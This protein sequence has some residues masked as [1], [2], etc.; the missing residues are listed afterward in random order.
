MLFSKMS[1]LPLSLFIN[2][3]SNVLLFCMCLI[4]QIRSLES[5]MQLLL[6]VQETKEKAATEVFEVQVKDLK[7]RRESMKKREKEMNDLRAE[8]T[9]EMA[10]I[11]AHYVE[12]GAQNDEDDNQRDENVAKTER[13]KDFRADS[14]NSVVSVNE[15]YDSIVWPVAT[16]SI[17]LSSTTGSSLYSYENLYGDEEEEDEVVTSP[18][19]NDQDLSVFESAA[20]V[21]W[22]GGVR[23]DASAQSGLTFDS[24]GGH[25]DEA[26][27]TIGNIHVKQLQKKLKL[28]ESSLLK[29]HED[30]E[31][32]ER[33]KYRLEYQGIKR[34][35]QMKLD[36]L[37]SQCLEER[38]RL[39]DDVTNRMNTLAQNQELST[40]TVQESIDQDMKAMQDALVEYWRLELA[41]KS[42]F[43]KAQA[44]IS[45]QVFHEVRNALSSV[46]AMSEMTS[47]LKEDSSMLPS[48]LF[49]YVNDMLLQNG[50]VVNYA[51]NMLNNVMDISKMKSGEF[52][53]KK[54]AFDLQHLVQQATTMQLVKAEARGVK[55]NCIPPP[56]RCIA[57]TDSDIVSRIITNFISNAVKFTDSG[58]IQPFVLPA[59]ELLPSLKVSMQISNGKQLRMMAVGVADT[60]CGLSR[61][62]LNL[63]EAGLFNSTRGTSNGAKNRYV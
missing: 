37:L 43:D 46:V 30:E 63:A 35:N 26:L 59:K 56:G 14:L 21:H 42:S 54:E 57:Y 34:K 1:C 60:G 48:E 40:K 5:I 25:Q 24:T 19:E 55:M 15:L 4:S 61:E 51:L 12:E 18:E 58:A 7:S 41:E 3:S 47:T 2:R 13:N 16:G 17:G 29:K 6:N 11:V 32:K 36:M 49:S 38:H 53:T 8:A 33:R 62:V 27:V 23:D 45:A 44:L 9:L 31:R 28:K 22:E 50:V 52:E 20:F 10:Q 39:R